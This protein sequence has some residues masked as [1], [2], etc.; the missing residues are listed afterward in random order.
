MVQALA[1]TLRQRARPAAARTPHHGG[2]ALHPCAKRV[3]ALR[4]MLR[5]PVFA[6]MRIAH[7]SA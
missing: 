5:S 1:R 7:P 6:G 4:T 2:K 3:G